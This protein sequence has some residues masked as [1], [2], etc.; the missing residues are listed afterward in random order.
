MGL[1]GGSATG[2]MQKTY[3]QN[4]EL[5]NRKKPLKERIKGYETKNNSTIRK[6]EMTDEQRMQ[7][8]A[9]LKK[10]KRSDTLRIV[11]VFAIIGA[12]IGAL[13]IYG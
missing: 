9:R 3:K 11:I 6:R 13:A 4:K 7:H 1:L 5:G 12:I 8:A 10:N 2:G